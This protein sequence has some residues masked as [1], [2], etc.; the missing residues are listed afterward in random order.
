M[1]DEDYYVTENLLA[2]RNTRV[3]NLMGLSAVTL[4][5]DVKSA[6]LMLCG[7]PFQEEALLR[8][9]RAAEQVLLPT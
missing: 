3:G 6:G 7:Q 4:P 8:I 9:A 2:L 5:T 1:D